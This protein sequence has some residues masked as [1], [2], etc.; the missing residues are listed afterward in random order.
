MI[1]RSPPY[2]CLIIGSANHGWLEDLTIDWLMEPYPE[3]ISKLFLVSEDREPASE[4]EI[5]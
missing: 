3:D 5:K 2:R 4:D 1:H